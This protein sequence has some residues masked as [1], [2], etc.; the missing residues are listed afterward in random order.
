VHIELFTGGKKLQGKDH[1]EHLRLGL[2]IILKV[3]TEKCLVKFG[4]N[5]I[6]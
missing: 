6:D 5:S 3:I 2:R 1:M 4:S